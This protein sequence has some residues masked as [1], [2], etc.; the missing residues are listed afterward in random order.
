M[1]RRWSFSLF[2]AATVTLCITLGLWQLDRQEEKNALLAGFEQARQ[3]SPIELGNQPYS[4]V[5]YR[6]VFTEGHYLPEHHQYIVGQY[7]EGVMGYHLISPFRT[8]TDRLILI[9]RGWISEK[10][11]RDAGATVTHVSGSVMPRGKEPAFFMP[12]HQPDQG[13]W[14]NADVKAIAAYLSYLLNEHVEPVLVQQWPDDNPSA[15]PIATQPH[16][17]F[18][19]DHRQYAITWFGLAAV[20]T[21]MYV[22]FIIKTRRNNI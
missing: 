16:F 1:I 17:H 18:R 7:R 20:V 22:I 6:R 19:N 12:Q 10:P 3:A 9:N 15:Q 2:I 8:V 13:E 11:F 14:I 21:I 4:E 5:L